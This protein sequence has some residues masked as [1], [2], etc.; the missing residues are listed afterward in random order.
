[1]YLAFGFFNCAGAVDDFVGELALFVGGHLGGDAEGGFFA[2]EAAFEEAFALLLGAAP[3]DDQVVEVFVEACLDDEGG[4]D[5]CKFGAARACERGKPFL[6]D[7][8]NARVKNL[9]EAQAL[10]GVVEYDGAEFGA[11]D[12]IAGT[13]N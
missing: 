1:M 2:G 10:G 3:A 6:D 7:I 11:I 12:D 13:E 4:F 5:D 8:E 9:V